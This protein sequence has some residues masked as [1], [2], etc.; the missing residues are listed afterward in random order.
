MKND[1]LRDI[2]KNH[3]ESERE[4]L[5]ELF[6]KAPKLLIKLAKGEFGLPMTYWVYGVLAGF[7]WSVGIQA[8]SY[9]ASSVKSSYGQ[10]PNETAQLL[11]GAI[12]ILMVLYYA[13][14]YTGIWNA[15]SHYKG[16]M[17]WAILAK[18][19]VIIT[20]LPFAIGFISLFFQ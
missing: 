10:E 4:F 16:S 9:S 5:E 1:D 12:Y 14:V 15:S 6:G 17:I 13:I 20:T 2:F 7:V 8:I 11:I 19:V 3:A 18:F